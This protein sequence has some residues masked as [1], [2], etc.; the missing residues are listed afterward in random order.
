MS[1]TAMSRVSSITARITGLMFLSIAITVFLL[2]YLADEQMV[3]LF[4]EYL[5]VQHTEMS[6]AVGEPG[7]M[8]LIMGPLET[9]FLASVHQSLIWVGVGIMLVGLAA[10][11]ALARSITVPLRK[12]SRAAEQLE[13]G[14]LGQTV[15]V[16]SNDEVGHLA[17]IFNRMSETLATNTKLRRQL[18]ANIAHELKTPLAVIQGNLE[19][20]IDEV[21]EP[22][23]EQL[24]SLHEEA[25][26]LNRLIKDLRDLSLAEVR[27]LALEKHPININQ[28][29]TRTVVMLKPLS[30][31]KVIEVK[32]V[33][34][35]DLPEIAVDRDRMLQVFYNILVNAIR[36]SPSKSSIEV[37]TDIVKNQ[38]ATWLKVSFEDHGPGISPEDL[39]HVFDHF[40][41]ADKSR[42][43]KS[44]GSGIGLAIVKQLVENHGGQVT[45]ESTLGSGSIFHVLLPVAAVSLE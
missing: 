35:D 34:K 22:G 10:S 15:L 19:G 24:T 45:V 12:L 37:S 33:L 6:H 43:R 23:K 2:I 16:E 29:V 36:Y 38:D 8:T 21:I 42:D 20:M 13:Q 3:E 14:N 1:V 25:V 28:L 9:S 27:E 41:R 18:L 7:A 32:S 40:Y 31:E 26:R 11:Y 17:V 44:G 39:P 4:Q 30:D 5:V